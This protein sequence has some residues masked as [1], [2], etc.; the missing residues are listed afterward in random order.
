[1]LSIASEVSEG[2]YSEIVFL[3]LKIRVVGTGACLVSNI[4]M[5]SKQRLYEDNRLL[6][7][8]YSLP[9]RVPD[10]HASKYISLDYYYY[11][12]YSSSIP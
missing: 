7:K 3:Y 6:A 2:K 8:P 1:M 4:T 5:K 9:D 10:V 11:Y 12:Y